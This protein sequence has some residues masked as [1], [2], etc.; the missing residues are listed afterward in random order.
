MLTAAQFVALVEQELTEAGYALTDVPLDLDVGRT[1]VLP[2]GQTESGGTFRGYQATCDIVVGAAYST[3]ED[4]RSAII[5]AHD[6]LVAFA[7]ES[8]V[9]LPG[10]ASIDTNPLI[11]DDEVDYQEQ[12]LV[13]IVLPVRAA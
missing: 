12:P 1:L 8:E 5:E 11:L 6:R 7:W 9:M 2:T 13:V 3:G 10:P 4:A